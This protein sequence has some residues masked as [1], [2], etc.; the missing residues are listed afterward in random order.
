MPLTL[1]SGLKFNLG[2]R[3]VGNV[4]SSNDITNIFGCVFHSQ[5]VTSI[6]RSPGFCVD[7]EP[8]EQVP[9]RCF[10]PEVFR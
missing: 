5:R 2:L 8:T 4:F 7:P 6:S 9:K 10:V 3:I 1:P